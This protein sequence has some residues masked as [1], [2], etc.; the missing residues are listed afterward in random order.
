MTDDSKLVDAYKSMY[1][2][3]QKD[4]DGKVI[5]HEGEEEINEILGAAVA[6]ATKVL[7]MIMKG[8][9]IASKVASVAG[10]A[11]DIAKGVGNTLNPNKPK[12]R[13]GT[14]T[15]MENVEIEHLDGGTTEIVDVVTP[16]PLII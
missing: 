2:H 12:E 4:A 16:E 13:G 15:N 5:E 14:A 9:K 1:E 8:A 7:P 11:M 10:P 3:H 6:G